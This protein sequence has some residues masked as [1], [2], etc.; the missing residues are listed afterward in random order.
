MT[1]ICQHRV[2]DPERLRSIPEEHG[3]EID[4]RSD[5][6]R[7]VLEHDPFVGGPTFDEWLDA[8]RHAFIVLNIKEE[9]L[10]S[11][12]L[13]ALAD[14]GIERFAFL[15]Q[16]FPFLVRLLRTGDTRMMV[17]VS[18]F[19]SPRTA[20]TLAPRPDWIWVDSFGGAWPE[21]ATLGELA[22][23]GFRLMVVSPELQGR[24]PEEEVPGI[25]ARFRQAGVG[26]DG[27][28]TKRADLW[29]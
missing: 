20:L 1:L 10:E 7:V 15:D 17:R 11:A 5:G 12:V 13:A 29:R 4:L 8:Y 24:P 14:R 19:E 18:E 22:L 25:R 3:V 23:A 2:N 27:V 26:L 9:G 28:C 6:S 16:S 21:P